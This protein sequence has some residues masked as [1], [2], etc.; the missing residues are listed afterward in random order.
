MLLNKYIS[1]LIIICINF[2]SCGYNREDAKDFLPGTYSY[3]ISTGELQLLKI[4]PDFSFEQTIYSQ[5][6]RDTLFENKG[7]IRVDRNKIDFLNYLECYKLGNQNELSEPRILNFF[8][9]HWRK[10]DKTRGNSNVLIIMFDETN[11]IFEKTTLD[12]EEK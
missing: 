4:N 3:K 7:H 8:E 12:Q 11:Y 10:P 2:L 1:L 5:N 6:G 9:V